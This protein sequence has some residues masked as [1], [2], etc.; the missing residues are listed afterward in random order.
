D[1][2]AQTDCQRLTCQVLVDFNESEVRLWDNSDSG[3]PERLA[4]FSYDQASYVHSG[5]S[6][7]DNRF[8]FVHDELDETSYSLN[9]TVRV[10]SLD[11]LRSPQPANVWRGPTAAIDHNG[12]VRGN[13]YYMSNYQRG[14]TVLDITNPA[15]PAEVGFFDTFLPSDGAAFN[16]MWG[17]Y[18]YLPS[19]LILG[20]DINSGLYVLADSSK[21]VASG[22]VSFTAALVTVQPGDIASISVQRP[23]GSG[24]VSVGYQSFA[25]SAV[26]GTD[27]EPATGRLSWDANDNSSKTINLITADSGEAG[28]RTVFVRL[29]DPKGGATLAAPALTTVAFGTEPA[30]SGSLSLVQT[31][32]QAVEGQSITLNVQRL[33]GSDGA[34]SVGYDLIG[35]TA[36][37]G[38]DYTDSSG[39]LSWPDGDSSEKAFSIALIDDNADEGNESFSVQLRSIDG[40]NTGPNNVTTVT[41]LDDERNTAPVISIGESRHVNASQTVILAA[42]AQDVENDPI[43][44]QWQQVSGNPVTLQNAQSASASFVAPASSGSLV[45]S[46][47]ATDSRGAQTSAQLTI[48]VVLQSETE[49][50]PSSG[51]G[52]VSFIL[53][54]MLSVLIWQRSQFQPGAGYGR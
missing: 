37:P 30:R 25:G 20:S 33:G 4:L 22:A 18:P 31:S 50:T 44:Y 38:Q 45:F 7:E 15:E 5:W 34:L 27:Y 19:G 54:L 10:F 42:S 6:S 17:T 32:A 40:S 29:Y 39:S 23:Q 8:L 46:V 2:R 26:A 13:R 48:I 51:G 14:L 24:A 28:K 1:A 16:G 43:S 36:Q 11:N 49:L 21:N 47:S 12:Y 3:A 52:S 41:V 9:T 35:A 53:L